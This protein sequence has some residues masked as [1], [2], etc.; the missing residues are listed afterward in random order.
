MCSEVPLKD[1]VLNAF[2]KHQG[3]VTCVQ[4]SPHHENIFISCGTDNEIRIY[5]MKQVCFSSIVY[6]NLVI[7]YLYM[8]FILIINHLDAQNLFYNKFISC[9]YMFRA[10]CAHRQE[11]KIVLYSPWYHR[12]ETS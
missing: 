6:F 12:T 3:A 8:F 7:N 10:P 11:V 1:P 2:D 4:S 5:H 9:L